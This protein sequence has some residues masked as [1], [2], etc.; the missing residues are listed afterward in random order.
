M[1]ILPMFHGLEARATSPAGNPDPIRRRRR[2]GA[3]N[4]VSVEGSQGAAGAAA[5]CSDQRATVTSVRVVTFVRIWSFVSVMM[6]L[7]FTS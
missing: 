7:P 2:L 3:R 1:G 4:D 6:G 5:G